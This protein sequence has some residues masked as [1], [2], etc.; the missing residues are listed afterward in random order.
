MTGKHS[1]G[2]NKQKIIWFE[3]YVWFGGMLTLEG[4]IKRLLQFLF[5]ISFEMRLDR[6]LS[7]AASS[8][9]SFLALSISVRLKIKA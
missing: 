6:V 5:F 2:E 3:E 4:E 8:Y 1:G 7:P 9:S